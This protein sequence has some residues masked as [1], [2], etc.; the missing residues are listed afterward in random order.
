[1]IPK[2]AQDGEQ[3]PSARSLSA[4]F[5]GA[6]GPLQEEPLQVKDRKPLLRS[7]LRGGGDSAVI[8][9]LS[10]HHCSLK[11]VLGDLRVPLQALC[12]AP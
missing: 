6:P 8:V 2:P 7:S 4:S 11:M 5:P 10:H 3:R 12:P 1:M 9:T